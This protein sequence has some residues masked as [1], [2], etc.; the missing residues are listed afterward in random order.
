M[1]PD[2]LALVP[3]EVLLLYFSFYLKHFN[4]F[5]VQLRERAFIMFLYFFNPNYMYV[6]GISDLIE[7]EINSNFNNRPYHYYYTDQ[8]QMKITHF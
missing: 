6:N 1:T 5:L 8:V 7:N 3:Y 2:R 4:Y